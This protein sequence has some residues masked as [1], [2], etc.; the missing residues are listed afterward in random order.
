MIMNCI[1]RRNQARVSLIAPG[2]IG[3]REAHVRCSTRDVSL[4][5]M[6][7]V[8]SERRDPGDFVRAIWSVGGSDSV[9]IEAVVVHASQQDGESWLLGLRFVRMSGQAQRTIFAHIRNQTLG[10]RALVPRKSPG[11]APRVLRSP[12]SLLLQR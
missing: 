4:G 8:T 10:S 6:A 7:L 5:G 9:E 11:R 3:G 12:A 2:I 1:D